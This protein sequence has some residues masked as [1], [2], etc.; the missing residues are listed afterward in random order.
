LG[1]RV[2]GKGAA[3]DTC[4]TGDKPPWE[5]YEYYFEYPLSFLTENGFL[6]SAGYALD[7][8]S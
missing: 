6:M 3:D 5:E 4:H 1:D 8:M 7:I 2:Y